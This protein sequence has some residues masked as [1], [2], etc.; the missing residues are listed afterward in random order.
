LGVLNFVLNV[1][2]R[3]DLL[4]QLLKHLTQNSKNKKKYEPVLTF[5]QTN[6]IMI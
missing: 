2:F 4:L 3:K 1:K 6:P 5:G